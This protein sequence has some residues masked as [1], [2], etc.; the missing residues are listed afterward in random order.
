MRSYRKG[1]PHLYR[2]TKGNRSSGSSAPR[3]SYQNEPDRVYGFVFAGA[4][5]R[6]RVTD[7]IAEV[8]DVK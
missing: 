4:E 6:L 1:L 3:P 2:R 5:I 7:G 8:V